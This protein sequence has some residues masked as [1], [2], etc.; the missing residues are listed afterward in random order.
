MQG[1]GTLKRRCRSKQRLQRGEGLTANLGHLDLESITQPSGLQYLKLRRV[2]TDMQLIITAK[3]AAM[4]LCSSGRLCTACCP[5]GTSYA[6]WP[7]VPV[8]WTAAAAP[9]SRTP[10]GLGA[11]WLHGPS[12]SDCQ[13][14]AGLPQ[15]AA[16]RRA[17]PPD[18]VHV[19]RMQ[20]RHGNCESQRIDDIH[21]ATK[22]NEMSTCQLR[23]RRANGSLLAGGTPPWSE[24]CQNPWIL[25]IND[26]A[27]RK[28]NGN[29]PS[30]SQPR[31]PVTFCYYRRPKP[32]KQTRLRLHLHVLM[33]PP[34]QSP[35]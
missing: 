11:V 20:A 35:S 9:K 29:P 3:W 13:R 17:H 2:N 14:A 21:A 25:Q 6:C 34:C 27:N 28:K 16:T 26:T 7:I 4:S 30:P 15:L 18:R 22:T 23:L 1:T 5:P 10:M 8:R 33:W 19:T 12:R 31:P 32:R 24:A